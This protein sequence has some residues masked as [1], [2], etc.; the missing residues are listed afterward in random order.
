M[1]KKIKIILTVILLALLVLGGIGTYKIITKP[2]PIKV[3]MISILSGDYSAVGENF[4]NGAILASE[5]YNLKH[6]D[7][8]VQLVVEDDGYDSKKALSAYQKLTGIDHID[9]LIN[10][11]TPSIGAIYDLVTKTNIPVIQGGEQPILP[12]NDNVFQI[13][14]GN[15]ELEKSLGTYIYQ[16]GYVN[17]AIVYTNDDTMI[18]FK[19]AFKTGYAS[20]THDFVINGD[21]KDFKSDIVKISSIKPDIIIILMYPESGAQL[22]KQYSSIKKLPKLAFDANAQ[23]GIK[24]YQR[25]LNGASILNG[26]IIAVV[27]TQTLQGFKDTYK[28]RFKSEPGVFSDLGYDAFVTLMTTY[29]VDGKVWISNVKSTN[30]RGASGPVQFDE[31]GVRKPS[32]KILEITNGDIPE[33]K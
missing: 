28:K 32:V 4:R 15:I 9:A 19:D 6:P 2:K 16:K 22:I 13:L 23:S 21:T 5:Q 26:S 17:P 3:G 27:S 29:N 1:T 30:R 12:T 33:S 14:P 31:V 18:R 8:K 24:D 11:S 10:V 25:I 20:S 7:Q